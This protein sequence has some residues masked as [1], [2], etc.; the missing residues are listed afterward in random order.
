MSRMKTITF[1]LSFIYFGFFLGSTR[2]L[3]LL[4]QSNDSPILQKSILNTI[5][6]WNYKSYDTLTEEYSIIDTDSICVIDEND[7]TINKCQYLFIT[8]NKPILNTNYDNVG[9]LSIE[10]QFYEYFNIKNDDFNKLKKSQSI[11]NSSIEPI[12]TE[13]SSGLIINTSSHNLMEN[14]ETI[15]EEQKSKLI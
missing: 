8:C 10:P 14:K 3:D 12:K 15:M 11:N 2:F 9:I 4:K 7:D 5:D 1:R 13:D 6:K